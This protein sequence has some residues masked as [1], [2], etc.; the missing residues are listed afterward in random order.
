M[1]LESA[2]T[3][4]ELALRLRQLVSSS[5]NIM[6]AAKSLKDTL[7]DIEQLKNSSNDTKY[8]YYRSTRRRIDEFYGEVISLL[9]SSKPA[10][11]FETL[12]SVYNNVQHGYRDALKELYKEDLV[13]DLTEVEFSTL[14]NFNREMYTSEKSILFA[15]KDYLLNENE[16]AGFDELPGFIR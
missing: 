10:E 12:T 15:L 1:R 3:E 6:Y 14:L 5:R 2:V 16:S 13:R 9:S 4:K 7:P 8:N 11:Y